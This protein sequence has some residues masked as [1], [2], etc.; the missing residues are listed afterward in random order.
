VFSKAGETLYKTSFQ[1]NF[2]E[3]F[4][5]TELKFQEILRANNPG[6]PLFAVETKPLTLPTDRESKS[7]SDFMLEG[8]WTRAGD[9]ITTEDANAKISF[10]F[11]GTYLRLIAIT[12]PKAREGAKAQIFLN[13]TPLAQKLYGTHVHP[14]D[15]GQSI[16]EVNK[17][18]G[19]YEI[20]RSDEMI[21]GTISIK[22]LN[23]LEN[24]VVV[25]G[26]RLV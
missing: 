21:Q 26:L 25:Y 14:G 16:L 2:S 24:P 22:F 20:I 15:R 18:T 11:Q 5:E 13:D 7:Y 9:A 8:Y 3:Q 4:Y 6:L 10:P 23:T 1:N 19:V 17:H 12:H